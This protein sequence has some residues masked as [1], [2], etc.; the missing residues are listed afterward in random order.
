MEKITKL[1]AESSPVWD[2]LETYARAQ[3]QQ[4]VQRL[5]EEEVDAVL[6]RPKS[7]RR[8]GRDDHGAAP[9]RAGSR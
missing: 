6:G 9:A 2:T 4:F 1:G 5:L 8:G 3:I 7:D